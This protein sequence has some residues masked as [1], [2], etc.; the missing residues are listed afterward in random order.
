MP[1]RYRVI[2]DAL[3]RRGY[4]GR[5]IDKI[6]GLNFQRVLAE[7]WTST[8]FIRDMDQQRLI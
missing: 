2:A 3:G 8:N 5:V 6:L 4:K 7:T 1:D